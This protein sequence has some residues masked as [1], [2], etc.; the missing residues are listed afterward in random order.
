MCVREWK[1]LHMHTRTYGDRRM[2]AHTHVWQVG[3]NTHTTHTPWRTGE[4]E[5]KKRAEYMGSVSIA[6]FDQY[7]KMRVSRAH[8]VCGF[9]VGLLCAVLSVR[10]SAATTILPSTGSLYFNSWRSKDGREN[11]FAHGAATIEWRGEGKLYVERTFDIPSD[12]ERWAIRSYGIEANNGVYTEIVNTTDSGVHVGEDAR[13]YMTKF[14]QRTETHI[15]ESFFCFEL[16]QRIV[17]PV[18]LLSGLLDNVF[19]PERIKT[20]TEQKMWDDKRQTPQEVIVRSYAFNITGDKADHYTHTHLNKLFTRWRSTAPQSS[21]DYLLER[22]DQN[23]K[24][25]VQYNVPI[26]YVLAKVTH[27]P[28]KDADELRYLELYGKYVP[29]TRGY[30][31]YGVFTFNSQLD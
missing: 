20:Y 9:V 4:K 3:N 14:Y 17:T 6:R 5:K 31:E 10:V 19:T 30:H 23:Q 13:T 22:R 15:I 1:K 7:L 8:C 26:Q 21:I 11:T 24:H 25:V 2:H 28:N 27:Y 12:P 16:I 29:Y 18:G